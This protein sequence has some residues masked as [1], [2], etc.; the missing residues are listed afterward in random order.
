MSGLSFSQQRYPSASRA[1]SVSAQSAHRRRGTA[2]NLAV[3]EAP[4]IVHQPTSAA[5]ADFD[6]SGIPIQQS[7]DCCYSAAAPRSLV[8]LG[9]G[10]GGGPAP[11]TLGLA[12]LHT[13]AL[14]L[15]RLAGN[16]AVSNPLND[17]RSSVLDV[18]GHGSGQAIEP[19]VRQ[20]FERRLG[21]DFSDV[22]VHTD[23]DA[24][25]SAQAVRAAAYTV[26]DEIVFDA[27][28]YQPTTVK[29]ERTLAHELTHVVQQRSGPV[30]GEPAAGGILVS[31]PSCQEEQEADKAANVA[32]AEPPNTERVQF[33]APVPSRRAGTVG[34]QRK[35]VIQRTPRPLT[36]DAVSITF[37]E[38]L[39]ADPVIDYCRR[40]SFTQ[41]NFFSADDNVFD[42]TNLEAEIRQIFGSGYFAQRGNTSWSSTVKTWDGGVLAPYWDTQVIVELFEDNVKTS[43]VGATATVGSQSGVT[44][45]TGSS[46][47]TTGSSSVSA[48]NAPPSA[49]GGTSVTGSSSTSTTVGTSGS[50]SVGGQS[51]G[52]TT[53]QTE[54]ASS[55]IF[56][57]VI[58][59]QS[60]HDAV[61]GTGL[62]QRPVS[63][64]LQVGT[65]RYSRPTLAAPAA[66][67]R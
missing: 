53:S 63:N 16:V 29:G 5:L 32:L 28:E 36:P 59:L 51:V 34:L 9:T 11:E 3:A 23:S 4:P 41:F 44:S 54:I 45:T 35:P 30:T 14:R 25:A 17:D 46:A 8:G 55:T 26:G 27:G 33:T 31:N 64:F 47:S 24:A 13:S 15:Q 58:L 22:R 50:I 6:F 57:R 10:V 20:V 56:A 12:P 2:R 43:G 7:V 61:L 67:G 48:T 66:P 39:T 40:N 19:S 65:T 52:S 18:V 62:R 21:H 42:N 60:N 49:Q 38:G 1:D 37:P